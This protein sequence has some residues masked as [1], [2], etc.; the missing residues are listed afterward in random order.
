MS[1]LWSWLH[2]LIYLRLSDVVSRS[3]FLMLYG[4]LSYAYVKAYDMTD[5]NI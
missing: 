5:M 1:A 2:S 3:G 4:V